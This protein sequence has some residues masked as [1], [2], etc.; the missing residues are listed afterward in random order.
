MIQMYV[1]GAII[2]ALIA[3]AQWVYLIKPKAVDQVYVTVAFVIGAMIIWPVTIA[4]L[5]TN[6]RPKK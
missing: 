3:L 5:I 2:V 1:F 6:G 4:M